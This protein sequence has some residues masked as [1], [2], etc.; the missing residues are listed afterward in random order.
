MFSV[1]YS[2]LF[3]DVRTDLWQNRQLVSAM[4]VRA[5]L[6]RFNELASPSLHKSGRRQNMFLGGADLSS[7][8]QF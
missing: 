6:T 2:M 4:S 8:D 1:P 7:P 3:G 5:E